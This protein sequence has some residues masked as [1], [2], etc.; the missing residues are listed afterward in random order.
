MQSVFGMHD[1]QHFNVF[2]YA[3]SP[4][5][6]SSYRVKIEAE[7]QHFVDVSADSTQ[8][9]VDRI[10]HDQIHVLINL[11]GYT[12]GAR[13]EVFAARPA[14]VQMS[15]MG[16]AGTLSAGWCDYFIVGEWPRCKGAHFTLADIGAA[17]PVVCPP[18]L[19][20]G[21]QW[22][23]TTGAFAGKMTGN[24]GPTDFEGDP[25][26]ESAREDFVY[27]EKRESASVVVQLTES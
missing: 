27:T 1:R 26:P 20:S 23:Y 11:S 24:E 16:F 7:A 2:C 12:K 22:R 21:T 4:S 15:Y 17:D 19:V 5:D 18:S 6:K 10:V 13:N 9:I 3:T 8:Q 14:P 25:D